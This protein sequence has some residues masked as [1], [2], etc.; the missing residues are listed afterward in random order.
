MCPGVLFLE[1]VLD[2]HEQEKYCVDVSHTECIKVH[3]VTHISDRM[4]KYKFSITCPVTLFV[5][6]VPVPHEHEK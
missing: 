3:Y 5:E 4:Q 2:P 1:S 6:S